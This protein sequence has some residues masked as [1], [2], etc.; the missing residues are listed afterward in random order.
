MGPLLKYS[1]WQRVAILGGIGG[2]ILFV[3][4]I[5]TYASFVQDLGSKESIMN[6]KNTGVTLQDRDGKPFFSLYEARSHEY[7]ELKDI[8]PFVPQALVATEDRNFYKH[9]GFSFRGFTRALFLNLTSGEV[10]QGGSTITQQLVKN[11]LL[12]QEQT[13]LR[14]YRELILAAEIERRYSK[15][16]ILEM[17]LNSAYFGEGAF[18]IGDASRTYYG[19]TPRRLTLAQAAELIA[20]L[21]APSR[22]SPITNDPASAKERQALVLDN[23]AKEGYIPAETALAAKEAP[24]NLSPSTANDAQKAHHFAY[25]VRD[26][27]I[28]RYGEE[29]VVRSGMTVRTTLDPRLQE[30]AEAQV[31]AQL[32]RLAGQNATNAAVVMMVPSSGEIRAMVGSRDWNNREFGQVNMTTTPR[33]PGSSIKPLVYA[34]AL[35]ERS[36]TPGTT[37]QD[38]E[39]DFGGGYRPLNYDRTFRGDV[40]PR[41]ALANSLNIPSVEVLQ[42]TGLSDARGMV[43][44]LGVE[45]IR[46]D[47]ST[48]LSF[49]LGT[50][51]APLLSMTNAFSTLA[52]GGERVEPSAILQIQDKRGRQMFEYTPRPQ[53]RIEA[54]VAFII[55]SFL[56]DN[57][58]RAEEFGSALNASRPAAVKTGTTEDFRDAWTIGYTP[59]IAVGVWMGNNNNSPMLSIAGSL[60]PAP[61]WRSLIEQYSQ[62][63][64]V[65]PF[66]QPAGVSSMLVCSG[67]GYR[68]SFENFPLSY[69]EYFLAG[70][71]PSRTCDVPDPREEERRKKFKEQLEEEGRR[72]KEERDRIR[73]Q[74]DGDGDG[75]TEG[76]DNPGGDNGGGDT[77]APGGGTS[78]GQ[79]LLPQ[80]NDDN[81]GRNRG[82]ND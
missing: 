6:R 34:A 29:R 68:A 13:L 57:R 70:T 4:A 72:L 45:D 81:S 50:S 65:R 79:P 71:E 61:I 41:R 48:G 20:V 75:G 5:F 36:I 76:G 21:P 3:I 63:L 78:D 9:E 15:E 32:S 64:P 44:R 51:E 2:A 28:R 54:G 35:A 24:L 74:L 26:E 27:L 53:R 14:K 82:G 80:T 30:T 31:R 40:L 66:R 11:T 17:Y 10:V 55:S 22:Y 42:K 52:N 73:D 69:R 56:S 19:V 60:G 18:G 16:E 7:V 33:Q 47:P 77:P 12:G 25:Y 58:A 62:D 38:V 37:L 8:P 39:T 49:A 46:V 67:S 59:D 23:M 1:P 43:K